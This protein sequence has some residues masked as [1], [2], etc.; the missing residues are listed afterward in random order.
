MEVSEKAKK[1]PAKRS[2]KKAPKTPGYQSAAELHALADVPGATVVAEGE[3]SLLWFK[4]ALPT[5][6]ICVMRENVQTKL[7]QTLGFFSPEEATDERASEI[8]GGGKFWG[9]LM[10]RNSMGREQILNSVRPIIPGE[11]KVLR[12]MYGAK[13]TEP[14]GADAPVV[15][16]IPPGVDVKTFLDNV[17]LARALDALEKKPAPEVAAVVPVESSFDKMLAIMAPA[18]PGLIKQFIERVDP[19]VVTLASAMQALSQKVDA[20][21][22]RPVPTATPMAETIAGIKSLLTVKDMIQNPGG[23][24]DEGDPMW[25]ALSKLADAIIAARGGGQ[26]APAQLTPGQPEAAASPLPPWQQLLVENQAR[27]L[28]AAQRGLEPDFV[29]DMTT[30]YVPA[31][32]RG[33]LVELV[34]QPNAAALV[35]QVIPAMQHYPQWLND[36]VAEVRD[37]LIPGPELTSDD[38]S[39][40]A[41]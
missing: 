29:A 32:Q 20:I 13:S 6:R 1:S 5:D 8:F 37:Q 28:D 22:N 25:S 12:E 33:I 16:R 41:A 38:V 26:P 21:Q 40:D 35:V 36:F 39:E 31:H 34:R 30:R 10:R 19:A 15:G 23:E 24:K 11:P 14:S 18:L 2:K 3:E 17:I 9:R 7:W 4:D 27:L